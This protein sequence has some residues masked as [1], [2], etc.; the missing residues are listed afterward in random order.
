[1][2]S[3]TV[4]AVHAMGVQGFEAVLYDENF[5]VNNRSPIHNAEALLQTRCLAKICKKN[6]CADPDSTEEYKKYELVNRS[7][8]VILSYFSNY[9]LV[10]VVAQ[11]TFHFFSV[12]EQQLAR[13]QSL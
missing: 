1:M 13:L 5:T 9:S 7:F 12:D 3:S 10:F 6:I 4:I 11:F 2:V 8:L